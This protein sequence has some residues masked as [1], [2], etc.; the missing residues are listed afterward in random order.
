M[1]KRNDGPIETH[2]RSMA[3]ESAE[4]SS[5]TFRG[6]GQYGR[7]EGS[8]EQTP[9][10]GSSGKRPSPTGACRRGMLWSVTNNAISWF[11]AG[12]AGTSEKPILEWSGRSPRYPLSLI[13]LDVQTKNIIRTRTTSRHAIGSTRTSR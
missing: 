6:M 10:T 9:I 11:A 3:N 1:S 13:D 12:G 5:I 8:D 7:K 4:E 2:R